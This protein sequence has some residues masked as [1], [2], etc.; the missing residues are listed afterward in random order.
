MQSSVNLRW[1]IQSKLVS[2]EG[3]FPSGIIHLCPYGPQPTQ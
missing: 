1:Y 3:H 2:Q